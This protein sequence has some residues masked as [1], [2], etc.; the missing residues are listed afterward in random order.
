MTVEEYIS[1]KRREQRALSDSSQQRR[2]RE[3]LKKLARK[4]GFYTV[5]IQ[6]YLTKKE[7]V[8]VDLHGLPNAKNAEQSLLH[9]HDYFELMYV[10]SGSCFNVFESEKITLHQG[11]ILLLNPNAKHDPFTTSEGDCL[12]NIM[13]SREL[14]EQSMLPLLSDNHLISNFFVDYMYHINKTQDYLYFPSRNTKAIS[15]FL[16]EIILEYINK[17]QGYVQVIESALVILFARLGRIF[18]QENHIESSVSNKLIVNVIVYLNQHSADVTLSS[19]AAEFGYSSGYLSKLIRKHTGQSFT[20]ILSNFKLEKAKHLLETTAHSTDEIAQLTG[21]HDASYL[22]RSFR[23][24]YG[25]T[26][27]SC[28]DTSRRSL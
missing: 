20:D 11:D 5:P 12:F 23:S 6:F 3:M 18:A 16:E 28:R 4:N 19:L 7:Q 25:V 8:A 22:S 13:L 26:P 2:L 27:S 1:Q 24:K 21:F 17:E 10:R 14:F 9:N 15:P